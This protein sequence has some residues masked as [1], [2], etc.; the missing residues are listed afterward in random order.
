MNWFGSS[1]S[2]SYQF[3]VLKSP[4]IQVIFMKKH[5]KNPSFEGLCFNL[6]GLGSFLNFSGCLKGWKF[7]GICIFCYPFGFLH[8]YP[9]KSVFKYLLCSIYNCCQQFG[10]LDDKITI[11]VALLR[12]RNG[13]GIKSCLSRYLQN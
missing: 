6:R 9:F 7:V 2:V 4:F 8:P 10:R 13:K 1:T 5:T 11:H 3:L 12:S